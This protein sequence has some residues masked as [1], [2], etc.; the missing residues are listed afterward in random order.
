MIWELLSALAK[1]AG[2]AGSTTPAATTGRARALRRRTSCLVRVCGPTEL[3][4]L[5]CVL[6]LSPSLS[7]VAVCQTDTRGT[8]KQTECPS[9]CFG[10]VLA[11]WQEEG[12]TDGVLPFCFLRGP[13]PAPALVP[14]PALAP[15]LA[16]AP[17]PAPAAVAAAAAPKF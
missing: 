2:A 13:A 7:F 15:A 1:A 4:L 12:E 5:I 9:I 3:H 17:G 10:D 8:A 11:P 14:A 16:L 6:S